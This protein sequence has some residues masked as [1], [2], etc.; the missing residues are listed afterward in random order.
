MDETIVVVVRSL[1]AF[2]TLLIFTRILGKQQVG[3]LTAFEYI[4]G[5]TVGSIA[6]SLSIDLSIKP[7]PI[8]IGI[9]IWVLLAY[10]LQ[11]I[12]IKNRLVAK[13]I[14]D[15]PTIVIQNGKILEENLKKTRYRYDELMSQLRDKDIFDITQVEFA[16]IEANGKITVLKKAEYQPVTPKDMGI[17]VSPLKLMIEIIQDGKWLEQNIIE[18]FLDKEKIKLQLQAQGVNEIKEIN[19]AAILPNGQI[20]VDKFRD[21]LKDEEIDIGDYRGIY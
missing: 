18:Q 12:S 21:N 10:I 11:I 8:W 16:L 6:A 14:D 17:T 13:I 19:Y 3:Q 5:I 9:G 2:F 4:L 1:I 15:Q 20:Y 7:F